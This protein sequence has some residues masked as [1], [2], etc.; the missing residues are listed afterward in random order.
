[1]VAPATPTALST[2]EPVR[3]AAARTP[4]RPTTEP[5]DKSMPPVTMTNVRPRARMPFTDTWSR[6]VDRFS[7]PKN[8]G[9]KAAA[10]SAST[11]SAA[12]TP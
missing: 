11:A 3:A 1:M 7:S 8:P 12:P 5:T 2:P 9:T 4:A 6:M 10:T